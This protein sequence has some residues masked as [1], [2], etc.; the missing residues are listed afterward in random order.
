MLWQPLRRAE[1]RVSHSVPMIMCWSPYLPAS[2]LLV[3]LEQDS[4]LSVT[5]DGS[6]HGSSDCVCGS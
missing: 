6:V 2:Q 5:A 3:V 1:M 4:Q